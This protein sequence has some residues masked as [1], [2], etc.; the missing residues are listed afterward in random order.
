MVQRMDGKINKRNFIRI[1]ENEN[2]IVDYDKNNNQYRVS[3]FENNHFL[4]E[5]YFT[6]Y[7]ENN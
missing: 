4:E 6:A 7:E 5:C 1:F 3:Y 2:F